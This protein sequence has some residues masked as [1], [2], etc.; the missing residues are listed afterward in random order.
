MCWLE[1]EG[2]H[3]VNEENNVFVDLLLN[4]SFRGC[5]IR[6][7]HAFRSNEAWLCKKNDVNAEYTTTWHTFKFLVIYVS[8]SIQIR[9]TN[10][11]LMSHHDSK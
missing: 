8:R 3:K 7:V 11:K 6:C 5:I 9:L 2:T 10:K 4:T 1:S